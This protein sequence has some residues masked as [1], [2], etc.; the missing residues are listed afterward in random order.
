M[1]PARL[2]PFIWYS[3]FLGGMIDPLYT[4]YLMDD[5]SPMWFGYLLILE[6]SLFLFLFI[7][8]TVLLWKFGKR[9]ETGIEI[10][11]EPMKEEEPA[12]I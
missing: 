3:L 6:S 11:I 2:P 5:V 8:V 10:E 1:F 12:G 4:G 9:Q 7:I